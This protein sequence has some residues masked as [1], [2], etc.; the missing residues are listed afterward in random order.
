MSTSTTGGD[1]VTTIST[2]TGTIQ[3]S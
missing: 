3:F 1:K 2:G